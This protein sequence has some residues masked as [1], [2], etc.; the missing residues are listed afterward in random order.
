MS[1]PQSL[2][3]IRSV[4]A[5]LDWALGAHPEVF[6]FGEDVAI[7]NGPF[8]ATKGLHAKYGR[9]VFDTPISESAMV[10]AAL[11]AAMRGSRPVVEIM[12]MDF[13]LVAMDQIVN[14]IA[15]TRYVSCGRWAAPLVVRTQGGY[16]PGSCAQH[17]HMLETF[18]AH[19]PGLRVGLPSNAADAYGMLRAAVE[20]DD[21]VFMIES[22][23]LYPTKATVDL[24]GPV[25]DIGGSRQLRSGDDLTIVAWSQMVPKALEA[26]DQ[27]AEDGIGA[28]VIDL[29]WLSPLDLEPVLED[30]IRTGRTIVTHEAVR[31]GGFGAEIAATITEHCFD[32]MTAPVARVATADVPM[33][34]APSLQVEAVP[35]TAHLVAEARRLMGGA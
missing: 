9:R 27:L 26:A 28:S 5:A 31:T 7:P 3:Y 12:Y 13:A 21:P 6:V 10:G 11:G 15:P 30:V 20:S 2:N 17:S 25:E 35:S 24:N 16:S 23:M 1:E 29:R 22:R 19:T 8:G 34:A 14:Q 33:P 32:S 4:N 18:L